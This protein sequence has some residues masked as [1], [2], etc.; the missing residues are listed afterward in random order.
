MEQQTSSISDVIDSQPMHRNQY[1]VFA[2]CAL[3]MFVDGIDTQIFSFALPHIGAEWGTDKAAFGPLLSAALA[4]LFVGYTMVSPLSNRIG[5][6]PLLIICGLAFGVLTM[7]I[8]FAQSVT[9]LIVLRFASGVFLAGV[10]PSA[11]AITSEFTPKQRRAGFIVFLH[12][13][14][15][16]GFLAAGLLAGSI[17]PSFGWRGLM[18]TGGV[19]AIAIAIALAIFLPESMEFLYRRGRQDAIHKILAWAV[20]RPFPAATVFR[21]ASR[22]DQPMGV[23]A[24]LAPRNIGSSLLLWLV[25]IINLALFYAIVLWL[26]SIL[27]GLGY[28]QNVSITA[29]TLIST[30]TLF[31]AVVVGPL[32]NRY[33]AGR[34]LAGLCIFAAIMLGVTGYLL[35]LPAQVW[36]LLTGAVLLGVGVAG[37]VQGANAVAAMFYPP[38]M[39][40]IGTGWALGVGRLGAIVGPL[41]VGWL[42]VRGWAVPNIFYAAIVLAVVTAVII[43]IFNRLSWNGSEEDEAIASVPDPALH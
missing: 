25:F 30:S 39:R 32:M 35:S 24:L 33:G 3:I 18:F 8:A 9:H 20:G 2:L 31:V 28:S 37:S 6:K 11:M 38:N 14:F 27:P 7:M 17:L 15:G 16:M 23:S 21:G 19:L 5:H 4:G 13:G 40:A 29:T 1:L 26:P 41:S 10:V 12:M 43:T 22:V 34:V 36:L 42:F